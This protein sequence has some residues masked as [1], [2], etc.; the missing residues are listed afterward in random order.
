LLYLAGHAYAIPRAGGQPRQLAD[1]PAGSP[2]GLDDQ[3]VLSSS[4]VSDGTS[5]MRRSPS[6]GGPLAPFWTGKSARFRPA[7]VSP[8]PAG[9]WVVI[10]EEPFTDGATRRWTT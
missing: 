3:G 5:V 9:G 1:A 2:I 10:G 8:D 6:D 7:A 4:L